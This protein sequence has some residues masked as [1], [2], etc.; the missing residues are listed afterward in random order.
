MIRV[1]S[2]SDY[3]ATLDAVRAHDAKW[4]D[5]P[6]IKGKPIPSPDG[7]PTQAA[8]E[9]TAQDVTRRWLKGTAL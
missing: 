7:H 2:P 5:M 3:R 4:A 8:D 9:A 6:R 1:W